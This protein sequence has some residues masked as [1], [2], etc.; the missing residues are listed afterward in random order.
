MFVS[1]FAFFG[2]AAAVRSWRMR[3][4]VPLVVAG[5]LLCLPV[6]AFGDPEV[7]PG[8]Q[9]AAD[10]EREHVSP[11]HGQVPARLRLL[12]RGNASGYAAMYGAGT[13]FY[14]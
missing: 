1:G 11:E 2:G 6:V 5:L 10:I 14:P 3:A 13:R 12:R 7:T 4:F 9:E 8:V